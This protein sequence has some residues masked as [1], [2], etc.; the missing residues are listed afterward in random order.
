M[1][2]VKWKIHKV[3]QNTVY[4][5]GS[6]NSGQ[7]WVDSQL[8]FD[9]TV[10]DS[11]NK[12][13]SHRWVIHKQQ[14]ILFTTRFVKCHHFI[15]LPA[16]AATEFS[17]V[18]SSSSRRGWPQPVQPRS[19]Y[20]S[21]AWERIQI[22]AHRPQF[23]ALH[24][25]SLPPQ[26]YL[27]L[28]LHIQIFRTPVFASCLCVFTSFQR[29]CVCG[30]GPSHPLIMRWI[31]LVCDRY[32]REDFKNSMSSQTISRNQ[33]LYYEKYDKKSADSISSYLSWG[34]FSN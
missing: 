10:N 14:S 2:V 29:A 34:E 32:N 8:I 15:S 23:K 20:P 16:A 12:C 17:S 7:L 24:M 22:Q 18:L 11:E 25:N 31:S 4:I 9:Y 27:T 1:E 28:H 21:A 30:S 26:W 13:I 19:P 3:W 33:F 5:L 6:T